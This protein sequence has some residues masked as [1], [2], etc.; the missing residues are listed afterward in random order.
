MSGI[1]VYRI[2]G[3]EYVQ[4]LA[5]DTITVKPDPQLYLTYFMS[6]TVYSDDP[7]SVELEPALPFHLGLLIENRGYGDAKNLKIASSQPVILQNDKG[8][9]VDFSIIG[10]RFGNRPVA[11]TLNIEFGDIYAQSNI[12]GVWDLVS[13]VRGNFYN[14]TARFQYNG[15][16]D[17]GRLSLIE[18]VEI[19]ELNHLVRMTGEHPR[20][21]NSFGY[22]TDDGLDDFLVNRNPDA[23]YYPDTVFT[24]DTRSR[25]FSVSHVIDQA[26]FS[27]PQHNVSNGR[28]FV[29]VHHTNLTNE[30]RSQLHEWVYIRF[31][32]PMKGTDYL[33]RSAT[34]T[35]LNYTLIE[36]ANSWQ[37]T[38]TEYLK[39]GGI[40][41]QNFIHLFDFGIA[42]TYILEFV[43]Q[44]PVS[45]VR[46][47]ESTNTSFIV[48][49]DPA[50]GATSSFVLIK[51]SIMD[52]QYYRVVYEFIQ[53]TSCRIDYLTEGT[54]Y[55]IKVFTGDHGNYER[56]GATVNGRTTGVNRCGNGIVDPGEDC[57]DGGDSNGFETSNC[58]IAC[59]ARHKNDTGFEIPT[60]DVPSVNPS[61]STEPSSSPSLVPTAS[62]VPSISPSTNPTSSIEPSNVPSSHPSLRPS[63]LASEEPTSIPSSEPSAS[64]MPS[65]SEEPTNVASF[66]PSMRGSEPP[67]P[68]PTQAPTGPGICPARDACEHSPDG[69]ITRYTLHRDFNLI[70]FQFCRS[71]C[72]RR[73]MVRLFM[74]LRRFKCGKCGRNGSR[75][76][77]DADSRGNVFDREDMSQEEQNEAVDK[78]STG[79]NIFDLHFMN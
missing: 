4:N 40:E 67:S 44:P 7:F 6:R 30:A 37:T 42:E 59:V 11:N 25:N 3:I 56:I 69:A 49:W 55:T 63:P 54:Q 64:A 16:I 71:A 2:D 21:E 26:G 62:L 61:A 51:P 5:P 14:F 58:T 13:T 34:R 39:D 74:R 73:T 12:I 35:D 22:Y 27:E 23:F 33:L 53:R 45:N 78:T 41:E 32:D 77:S 75:D 43:L 17:D 52:D 50:V 20:M 19:Y 28:V 9:L 1:L 65:A 47:L 72:V 18:S 66:H 24:S 29:E 70:L 15:P 79:S 46:I 8:L 36:Q 57:D 31:D 48:A 68:N 76:D 60:S 38:W 10:S